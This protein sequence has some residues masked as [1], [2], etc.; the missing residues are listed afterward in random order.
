VKSLR[1]VRLWRLQLNSDKKSPQIIMKDLN[2]KVYER[3]LVAF[4]A[5]HTIQGIN[6]RSWATNIAK[7]MDCVT[8]KASLSWLKRWKRS[9][10]IVS[11]KI[12]KFVSSG[13]EED[14][15]LKKQAAETF[16][17]QIKSQI[18][19]IGEEHFFNADH[20]M[21]LK[22]LRSKRT[23]HPKG[24]KIVTKKAQNLAAT[25]HSHTLV[26]FVSCNGKTL[27]KALMILQETTGFNFGPRVKRTLFRPPN[28]HIICSKSGK[29][30]SFQVEDMLDECFFPDIESGAHLLLDQWSGFTNLDPEDLE[31]KWNKDVELAGIPAGC[32]SLIQP[33]DVS[34]NL[35]FKEMQRKLTEKII[36]EDIKFRVSDRNNTIK[37]V[38]FVF[39]QMSSPR[40]ENLVRYAWFKSGYTSERPGHFENPSSFA[41][42]STYKLCERARCKNSSFLRC[43]WCAKFFCFDHLFVKTFHLCSDFVACV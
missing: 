5:K 3:F 23:L 1:V 16:A 34:W 24:A 19:K 14:D 35:Y 2:T 4:K 29:Q 40:Y 26:P 11:R 10:G 31:I 18:E 38:S 30:H 25:T 12:T 43:A 39:H 28:L 13:Q 36:I 33:L 22:E 32:T 27:K 8:F 42:N 17:N 7:D 41:L 9:Y 20:T 15:E 21:I 6:I 37:L